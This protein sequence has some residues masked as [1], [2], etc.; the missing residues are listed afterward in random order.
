MN[1]SKAYESTV[2][3]NE[4]FDEYSITI[5]EELLSNL[6]WDESDV[7]EWR[8]NKD[9]TALLERVD[10]EFYGEPENDED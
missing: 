9:G 2:E 7:V 1:M 3:Y 5:P 6:G 10:P 8:M 4:D